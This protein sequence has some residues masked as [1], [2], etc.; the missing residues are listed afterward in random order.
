MGTSSC[1]SLPFACSITFH[2][3]RDIQP[4]EKDTVQLETA[5][6]TITQEY[7]LEFTSEYGISEDLH[8]KLPDR[9]DRIVDFPEGKIGIDGFVQ[10]DQRSKSC[11]DQNRH[12]SSCCSRGATANGH[13]KPADRYGGAGRDIRVFRGTLY[14]REV[15]RKDFD[16]SH[17]TQSIVGGKSLASIRV[18]ASSTVSAPASQETL[19]GIINSD[20]I[21]FANPSSVP[22]Q[23][24]A[25]LYVSVIDQVSSKGGQTV[26]EICCASSPSGPE[27]SG[28]GK[29]RRRRLGELLWSW[30]MIMRKATKAKMQELVKEMGKPSAS[31]IGHGLRLAVLKCVKSL[32]L[33]QTF[34][35]V[36]FI[37]ITKGFCDGLKYGG[38]EGNGVHVFVPIV[39]PQGLQIM[40][41]D[42][43]IQTELLED[44][45]S[46]RLVRSKSL[47]MM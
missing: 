7:L 24:I 22:E 27:D 2:L 6:S 18:G 3:P 43:A 37:G 25:Q 46:P 30:N 28:H 40:L 33:R 32:E 8:P 35:N 31:V 10:P 4:S 39:A 17:P 42:A 19:A 34:A 23:D 41:K 14:L 12:P 9:G 1:V 44:D 20:P 21:S 36:V 13:R 47:P 45:S 38:G 15:L 29:A 16:V 26:K 5:V 11:R